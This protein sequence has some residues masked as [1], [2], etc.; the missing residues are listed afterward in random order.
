MNFGFLKM[1]ATLKWWRYELSSSTIEYGNFIT[2]RDIFSRAWFYRILSF[3]SQRIANNILKFYHLIHPTLV[4]RRLIPK[5]IRSSKTLRIHPK[6]RSG[7]ILGNLG[8]RSVENYRNNYTKFSF[9]WSGEN[10]GLP[11]DWGRTLWFRLTLWYT[12]KYAH[13]HEN[14]GI[15]SKQTVNYPS[16]LLP[17]QDKS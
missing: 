7:G 17:I 1:Q 10:Y 16:L 14:I 2:N 13:S 12:S 15:D 5:P 8:F 9:Y 11:D 3:C 6:F 4:I